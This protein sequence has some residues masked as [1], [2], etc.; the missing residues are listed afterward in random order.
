M[1]KR[2]IRQGDAISP[3]IF[4]LCIE[5]LCHII[6]KAV[7]QG[8]WKGVKLSRYGPNLTHL[9]FADDMVLFAEASEEQ[10]MVIK[11]CLETFC[12]ASGQK[13]N[14]RKSNIMF[15]SNVEHELADKI[16]GAVCMEHT[17]EMGKYLGIQTIH[18][19]VTSSLFQP[20]LN[21]LMRSWM[22]GKQN[23]YP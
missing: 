11:E 5:C 1:P 12:A 9:L 22:D 8:R 15:S 2:E 17:R 6:R 7:E 14:Y 10:I 19:R 21:R 18:G 4:G 16:A 3:Y 20:L 23:T 13:V